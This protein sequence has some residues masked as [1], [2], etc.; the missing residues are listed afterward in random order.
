MTLFE[1]EKKYE[2]LSAQCSKLDIKK[3]KS[4]KHFLAELRI[5]ETQMCDILDQ[6]NKI[7]K[8]LKLK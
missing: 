2:E 7:L 4:V 8:S 1:L 3:A 5:L 6:K